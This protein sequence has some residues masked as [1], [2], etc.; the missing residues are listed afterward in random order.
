MLS[1][2]PSQEGERRKSALFFAIFPVFTFHR[3]KNGLIAFMLSRI[4]RPS[5]KTSF[6]VKFG[7]DNLPYSE[8]KSYTLVGV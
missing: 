8:N 1:E 3:T 4:Y 5:K 6:S 7:S 2:K